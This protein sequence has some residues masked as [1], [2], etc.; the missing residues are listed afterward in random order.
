M[1]QHKCAIV[2]FIEVFLIHFMSTWYFIGLF[3]Q[4]TISEHLGWF[5]CFTVTVNNPCEYDVS[6]LQKCTIRYV[7]QMGISE[8]KKKWILFC[9]ISSSY[10]LHHLA[11]PSVINKN[12][13]FTCPH[14]QS[15]KALN[16]GLSGKSEIV[17]IVCI[18]LIINVCIFSV[19]CVFVIFT[20][21]FSLY[22]RSHRFL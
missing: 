10:G 16:F 13:H 11:L 15:V 21:F 20:Y 19:C 17:V 7:C 2:N 1:E 9:Q 8:S 6:C 18:S 12:I 22:F 3:N 5:W 14:Q 4:F